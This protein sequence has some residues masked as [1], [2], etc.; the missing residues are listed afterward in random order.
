MNAF[1][2]DY[3][4]TTPQTEVLTSGAAKLSRVS[5]VECSRR[6]TGAVALYLGLGYIASFMTVTSK[7]IISCPQ[8][9]LV[10]I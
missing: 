5:R 9:L 10:Q 4:E 7:T 1:Y 8:S 6:M 3:E 2:Y